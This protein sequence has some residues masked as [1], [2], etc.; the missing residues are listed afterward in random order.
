MALLSKVI[1][2][3]PNAF[4]VKYYE[5][6]GY[7]IPKYVNNHGK[8]CINTEETFQ[9]NVTDLL[10]NSH[11]VVLVEC[12]QCGVKTNCS[13]ENYNRVIQRNDGLYYCKKC[14]AINFHAQQNHEYMSDRN[15]KQYVDFVKRVMKR[16]NYTCQCC[17][18]KRKLEVHHLDGF[19]WCIDK[20]FDV[21][22]GITLCEKCHHNFHL[23]YGN[24]NNTKQQ[25]LDWINVSKLEL[26]NYNGE[27]PS[28]RQIFCYEDNT[29][30]Q[31]VDE[32]VLL[33]GYKSRS[34]IYS[35]CNHKP[36]YNTAYGKHWFWY[37]EFQK[38]TNQQVN[39][40]LQRVSI[41]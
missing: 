9:V 15:T 37:D 23:K 24:K 28:S 34:N 1:N 10:S 11:E 4:T 3:K 31:S 2:I 22:N 18:L 8:L 27:L 35:V 33:N 29:L 12:D 41:D 20:R 5:Q 38:L 16:D 36:R 13:Y 21:T 6:L 30:Y 26:E 19:S 14:A 39:S 32:A 17:G 40:Y 7:D 25:Y